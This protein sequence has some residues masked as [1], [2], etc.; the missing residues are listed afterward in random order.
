M[1]S[2]TITNA[3]SEVVIDPV[4]G[5]NVPPGKKDLVSEH[6]HHTYYFCTEICL[7][8]FDEEPQKY[9]NR[10]SPHGMAFENFKYKYSTFSGQWN[11]E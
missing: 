11:N 5:M 7:K 3:I 1:P 9:V 6:K 4:C 2:R 8:A 10:K